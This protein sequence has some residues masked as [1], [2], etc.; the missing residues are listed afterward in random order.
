MA[1]EKDRDERQ[2]DR[3]RKDSGGSMTENGLGRD[4][5]QQEREAEERG[6]EHDI[7]RRQMPIH[8]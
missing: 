4:R 1:G 8:R 6:R 3:K 7:A 2:D 5:R